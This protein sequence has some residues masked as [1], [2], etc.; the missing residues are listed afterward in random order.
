VSECELRI[1]LHG[2]AKVRQ[3][4]FGVQHLHLFHALFK[5]DMR[6][7]RL[8]GDMHARWRVMGNGQR[9]ESEQRRK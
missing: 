2:I 1:G 9:A 8:G 7:R 3:A 5:E 4:V 6:L